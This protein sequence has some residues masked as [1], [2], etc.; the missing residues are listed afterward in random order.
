MAS[1]AG[2]CR[3][4]GQFYCHL[5][6]GIVH[7]Y[8]QSPKTHR[9]KP[10]LLCRVYRALH[11]R[12]Q[13]SFWV[14]P[15]ALSAPASPT[16]P[17]QNFYT[18]EASR[19]FLLSCLPARCPQPEPLSIASYLSMEVALKN[20][21]SLC[22]PQTLFLHHPALPDSR[23]FLPSCSSNKSCELYQGGDGSHCAKGVCYQVV[24]SPVL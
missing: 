12:L 20:P 14:F 23:W 24:C 22:L 17:Q 16:Q 4:C 1:R 2:C 15:P 6:S 19:V 3:A 21:P 7:L 13:T 10:Q 18:P 11:T 5:G 8:I 9:R